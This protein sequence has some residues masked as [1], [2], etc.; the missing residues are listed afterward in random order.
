MAFIGMRNPVAAVV[1]SH[2][3]GSAISYNTGF[4]IGN[5]VEA[6][7]SFEVNDNPDYGDDIIIDNDTGVN[8]YSGTLDINDLS[9]TVRAKLLGWLPNA[10]T[11]TAYAVT[12]DAAPTVGWGF[13]HVGMYKGT[14]HYDAY[15]FHKCQFSL[16]NIRAL[17]KQKQ[18]D[19]NHP[20]MNFTGLGAYIDDSGKAK[21]FDWMSFASESAAKSWLNAR[22]GIT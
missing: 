3:D 21:F 13:I 6:N 1:N 19:W 17:T 5:A 22:A 8:G 12:D 4:L 18:I 10:T 9:A 2:T 14:R 11:A 7:I 20:Q 15:W 16:Q